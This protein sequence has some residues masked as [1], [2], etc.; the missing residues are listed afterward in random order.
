MKICRRLS[1]YTRIVAL[2]GRLDGRLSVGRMLLPVTHS[3]GPSSGYS[4]L[5][6]SS[7]FESTKTSGKREGL[8]T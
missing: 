7:R 8:L 3:F 5:P 2:S 1:I 4:S 6:S